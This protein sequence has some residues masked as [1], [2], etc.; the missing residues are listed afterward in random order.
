MIPP[1]GEVEGLDCGCLCH[2]VKICPKDQEDEQYF[3]SATETANDLEDFIRLNGQA[4]E[5]AIAD[6]DDASNG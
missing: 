4:D 3:E 5:E 1:T 2:E 6:W